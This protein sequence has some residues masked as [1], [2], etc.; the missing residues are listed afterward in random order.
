M[1]GV[2]APPVPADGA[3]KQPGAFGERAYRPPSSFWKAADI[4]VDGAAAG[5]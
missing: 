1:I 5:A 2:A 3:A 4:A